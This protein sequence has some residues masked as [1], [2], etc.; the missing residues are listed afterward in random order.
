MLPISKFSTSKILPNRS[1]KI[2]KFHWSNF[3]IA[4]STFDCWCECSQ[5]KVMLGQ[6][7]NSTSQSYSSQSAIELRWNFVISYIKPTISY[8]MPTLPVSTYFPAL[9]QLSERL[10]CFVLL[11]HGFNT[12]IM[13]ACDG[14]FCIFICVSCI[15][16]MWILPAAHKKFLLNE[17][18]WHKSGVNGSMLSIYLNFQQ[19]SVQKSISVKRWPFEPDSCCNTL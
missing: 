2:L 6:C 14:K 11:Q 17:Q 13:C 9:N 1:V 18:Q 12:T 19:C 3:N 10:K 7:S 16:C 4:F 8:A 15:P 5:L